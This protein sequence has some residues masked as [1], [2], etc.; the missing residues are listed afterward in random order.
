MLYFG[1]ASNS[2]PLQNVNQAAIVDFTADAVEDA[3]RLIT[4]DGFGGRVEGVVFPDDAMGI[5]VAGIQRDLA[6]FV[7]VGEVV[8][9][10]LA[11]ERADETQVAFRFDTSV[12]FRPSRIWPGRPTI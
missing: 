10:D 12:N 4:L 6:V 5:N 9:V 7:A 8:I 2:Q 1:Q 3:V 11:D